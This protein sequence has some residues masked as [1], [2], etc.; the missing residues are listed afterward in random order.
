[1]ELRAFSSAGRA[2][3][4]QGGGRGF[5]TLNAHHLPPAD[6][7]R[8]SQPGADPR[9]R[10]SLSLRLRLARCSGGTTEP[11]LDPRRR[12]R[13]GRG[14]RPPARPL[15]AATDGSCLR[16][17]GTG[18]LVLVRVRRLLGRRR[19]GRHDQQPH[20]VAVGGHAARGGADRIFGAHPGGQHLRDRRTHEVAA[21]LEATGLED[22]VR[23]SG[24]EPRPHR[25]S[26]R[27]HGRTRADFR[28][29]ARPHR[30]RGERSRRRTG[31]CSSGSAAAGRPWLSGPGIA[32]VR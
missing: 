23:R 2:P 16:N 14:R 5:E 1:M 11:V 17:P 26:R 31:T 19:R 15:V 29:G 10:A 22:L 25:A 12:S 18:R 7:G 4:L 6:S 8:R 32:A 13:R 21:R 3:L 28:M 30:S 27:A 9:R 24:Q 20:G